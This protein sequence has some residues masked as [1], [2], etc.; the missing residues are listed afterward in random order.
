MGFHRRPT[1]QQVRRESCTRNFLDED[2][3]KVRVRPKRNQANIPNHYDDLIRC[4]QRTWKE[5]RKNQWKCI[6]L[7]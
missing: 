5:H 7:K 1:T 2:G 6:T 3:F 4:V